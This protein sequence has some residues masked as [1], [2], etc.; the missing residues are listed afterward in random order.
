MCKVFKQTNT[1][2]MVDTHIH[3]QT[4]AQKHTDTQTYTQTH[5]HTHTDTH[6]DTHNHPHQH[7]QP[8]TH[9]HTHTHRLS[10]THLEDLH[11]LQDQLLSLQ[12]VSG[13]HNHLLHRPFL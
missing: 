1:S 11:L 10:E 5:S 7:T 3:T 8:H 6:T 9:T 13:Q 4:H 2:E 12:V